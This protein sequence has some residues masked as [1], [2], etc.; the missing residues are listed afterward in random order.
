[1]EP[2]ALQQFVIDKVDDMK[3]R[4][5]ISLDLTGKST[6][7]DTFVICSGNSKRHVCAIAENVVMEMK[8]A[9]TPPISISGTE[10]GEWVV[11]DM[12]DVVL[13]VMQDATRDYFQLEKLWS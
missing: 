13:H 6:V 12:G 8:H 7:T 5:V 3:G 2:S 10:D 9:G 11:T 1:M 4:D